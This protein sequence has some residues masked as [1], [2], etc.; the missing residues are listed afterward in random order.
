VRF[1]IAYPYVFDLKIAPRT[2][3]NISLKWAIQAFH[4]A[5]RAEARKRA[6]RNRH[7]VRDLLFDRLCIGCTCDPSTRVIVRCRYGADATNFDG[8]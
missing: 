6:V 7:C 5:A 4:R 1:D 2:Y 8:S 3:Q